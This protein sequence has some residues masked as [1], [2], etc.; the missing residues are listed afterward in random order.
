[1]AT[2]PFNFR[3]TTNTET[4][5]SM[6]ASSGGSVVSNSGVINF[7]GKNTT[8]PCFFQNGRLLPNI[9][10]N[11]TSSINL[12]LKVNNNH[13]IDT[14]TGITQLNLTNMITGQSGHIVINNTAANTHSITWQVDGGNS[15]YIKWKGG[16]IPT[17]S[18]TLG[19]LDFISY[20][21]YNSTCIMLASSTNYF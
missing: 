16:S 7:V 4:Y 12:D 21:V 18:T 19:S 11:S 1:M 2:Q 8:D 9:M 10:T 17:M 20:Y 13:H 15:S 5:V 14:S 3:N 6:I